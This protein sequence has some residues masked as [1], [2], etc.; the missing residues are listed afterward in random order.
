MILPGNPLANSKPF[1]VKPLDEIYDDM[2]AAGEYVPSRD[3]LRT[4]D[5]SKSNFSD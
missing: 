3:E 2:E 4:G 1:N 5:T